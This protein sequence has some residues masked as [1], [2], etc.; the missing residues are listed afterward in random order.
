MKNVL[1]TGGKGQLANCVKDKIQ[2]LEDFNFI[3]VDY[4]ELDITNQK[5]VSTFFSKQKFE[6]CIN[7]AAY[8]AVDKA[9]SE[10][11]NAESVNVIGTRNLTELCRLHQTT[12]IQISTDFVFDGKQ[13]I[14]Y[15]E[16]DST[17]PLGVYGL[18]K[19]NSEVEAAKMREHFIIRTSWL[20][21]EH[22]NNF[23][24]TMLRL[25]K[26]RGELNVVYDQIGTP[27]YAGDLASIIL[28]I[29]TTDNKSYGVYHYSNEG[30]ASWYDFA[31]AIFEEAKVNIDLYPIE[32]DKYPT[33]ANR[34]SFSVLNKNK[35]KT[36]LDV[37]VPY[38]R[39]S[40][41]KAIINITNH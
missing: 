31:K 19:L 33:P 10:Y 17:N 34:P 23:F 4:D 26:E 14:P 32:T 22:N 9:E 24:K 30:V 8:T 7:C 27:T 40:L 35:I 11:Q 38:W 2:E 16:D 15:K 36:L 20:Y 28:K 37:E 12:L 13:S 5:E 41:K 25:G 18:T 1:V 6:Y 29:I 39:D 3:F 21:S